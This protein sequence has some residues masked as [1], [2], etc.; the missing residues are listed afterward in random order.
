MIFDDNE[1]EKIFSSQ[2][3]SNAM[4]LSNE[5]K[6][7][8]SYVKSDK[9]NSYDINSD[10]E[11]S[12]VKVSKFNDSNKKV[13]VEKKEKKIF[14][15]YEK[16]KLDIYNLIFNDENKEEIMK[17]FKLSELESKNLDEY[18]IS[19]LI[20][21]MRLKKEYIHSF[22]LSSFINKLSE[23][24]K[25]L[26]KEFLNTL[27]SYDKSLNKNTFSLIY[28]DITKLHSEHLNQ[29]EK[30]KK[31]CESS[32]ICISDSNLRNLLFGEDEK[33]C[34]HFSEINMLTNSVD[35]HKNLCD[36]IYDV[37]LNLYHSE[38]NKEKYSS[39]MLQ[40]LN[41]SRSN[42][43]MKNFTN[44]L[45]NTK[46]FQ[47]LRDALG[48][49]LI[50]F[51]LRNSNFFLFEN[52]LKNYVQISG[53]SLKDELI[54]LHNAQ[55]MNKYVSLLSTN[56]VAVTKNPYSLIKQQISKNNEK[57]IIPFQNFNV[58]RTKIFYCSN[59]N[60][61]LGLF[62]G[63]LKSKEANKGNLLL[64]RIFDKYLYLIPENVRGIILKYCD[65]LYL[66]LNKYDYARRINV[67]C[68]NVFV[69]KVK[70]QKS[71]F[72]VDIDSTNNSTS[73]NNNSNIKDFFKSNNNSNS[74]NINN[75]NNLNKNE[76]KTNEINQQ[77]QQEETEIILPYSKI[78]KTIKNLYKLC[79]SKQSDVSSLQFIYEKLLNTTVDK[80]NVC[81]FIKDF[82]KFVIP[83]DF[84]GLKNFNV[85]QN[86]I[87]QF[88]SFNRFETYNRISL[89]DKKEFSFEDMNW[90]NEAFNGKS[91]DK[92]L[93]KVILMKNFIMKNIIFFIFDFLVVQFLRSHFYVTERQGYNYKTFYYHKCNW[94]MILKITELKFSSHFSYVTQ[95]SAL[96]K[97]REYDS[98]YGKMRVVPKSNTFRP[99]VS[100]KKKTIKS[101]KLLKNELYETNKIFKYI[102]QKM[103][104]DDRNCVVFDHKQII[105]KLINFKE[106]FRINMTNELNK[107][108]ES[109]I[110]PNE[111]LSYKKLEDY[112]EI[113]N[114]CN[115]DI[116]ACYDNI[117][118]KKLV[119]IL[120]NEDI[121]A[122]EY[123]S[124]I[125]FVVL[126]K[127]NLIKNSE[128]KS[129]FK[130]CF[131]VKKIYYV[132]EVSEYLNYFEFL[133]RV[134][135]N[136][137]NCLIYQD[138]RNTDF[139]R[140]EQFLPRVKNILQNNIIRFNKKYFVQTKGIPQGLSVSSFLC[141]IYFYSLEKEVSKLYN[142][143]IYPSIID[144][145]KSSTLNLVL[146][147]ENTLLLRFMDD[148]LLLSTSKQKI[149]QAIIAL[150]SI[151][152]KYDSNFNMKKSKNNVPDLEIEVINN[153]DFRLN[154]KIN[155][156]I[157]L[158][159]I[160]T[161]TSFNY[162]ENL[163][164]TKCLK[165]ITT[166]DL[167]LLE[168]P[169]L[170][171]K[172][173]ILSNPSSDK[174]CNYLSLKS[175]DESSF[176]ESFKKNNIKG[177]NGSK[178]T[179][180]YNFSNNKGKNQNKILSC[181]YKDFM[182]NIISKSV[183]TDSINLNEF[184]RYL[185]QANECHLE[186]IWKSY[187]ELIP[188]NSDISKRL[189]NANWN[190]ICINFNTNNILNLIIDSKVEYELDKYSTL[191]NVTIPTDYR[192][193]TEWLYKKISSIFLTGHPWIFFISKINNPTSMNKN[194]DDLVKV[195]LFKVVVLFK[196]LFQIGVQFDQNS[197]ID[198]FDD[199][200]KKLFVYFDHK[201]TKFNC[202]FF[203]ENYYSFVES[204]YERIFKLYISSNMKF[205]TYLISLCPFLFKCFRRKIYR[206]KRHLKKT[207]I[208][209]NKEKSNLDSNDL[210]ESQSDNTSAKKQ[211][212]KNKVK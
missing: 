188:N 56:N 209:T 19:N 137:T 34:F 198:I 54:E 187:L 170:K 186:K 190:G 184:S 5:G 145:N 158:N 29:N 180:G 45:I 126:P 12:N 171:F 20:K 95:N 46:N 57:T 66:K 102:S 154:F 76:N 140:K 72:Y 88:V 148:Y 80:V 182:Y 208:H 84:I 90:L 15:K 30:F 127:K 42:D 189:T 13:K 172:S 85:I 104:E 67:F 75:S 163:N 74:N 87:F 157:E 105:H 174:K 128:E 93:K 134:E 9:Y 113:L 181:S 69:D 199:C 83:K 11:E 91:T 197:I 161:E 44:R 203:I 122:E 58:E 210:K 22:T 202:K 135:L 152:M 116:E 167:P 92:R 139:I 86:K 63:N 97:L 98:A 129:D 173:K 150:H 78:K 132:C 166:N 65:E 38:N 26:N 17:I 43:C 162:L 8:N 68:P 144:Y 52:N 120:D 141:N 59:Y 123:L 207:K 193:N 70:T 61:E 136:Y 10:F 18:C 138:T 168:D 100:F 176:S 31:F 40:S 7:S 205:N 109:Y 62:K 201:L 191:I 77:S 165:E 119:E 179:N 195:I 106:N 200:V 49:K 50:T 51:L 133:K 4:L 107:G 21:I 71:N 147:K 47:S 125:I 118:I 24:S 28:Y 53:M 27:K 14:S 111:E 155:N 177:K 192:N 37:C 23:Y 185:N 82:L 151:L 194:F 32:I 183:F 41:L 149:P 101:K 60:R 1:L 36:L 3:H 178:G 81:Y 79:I 6:N 175:E 39:L 146:K 89:F 159:S 48:D 108:D 153:K 96:E 121:I 196:N 142:R 117:N 112:N 131:E 114:F 35:N 143:S 206:L 164:F 2:P 64:N 211:I 33:N 110:N 25:F 130:D 115:M 103:Q 204:F 160:F 73:K 212:S 169:Q 16:D 156:K 99:I 94:S 55:S 124:T